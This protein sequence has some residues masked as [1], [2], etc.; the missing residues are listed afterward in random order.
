M[1]QGRARFDTRAGRARHRLFDRLLATVAAP[2]RLR[3][4]AT[5]VSRYQRWGVQRLARRS[6]LLQL[7]GLHR[8][9]ALLPAPAAA[10]RPLPA[11]TPPQ[12]AHRGDVALFTGCI[13]RLA[14]HAAQ[15]ATADLLSRLGYGVHAPAA[16][17]CCGAL[18]AHNGDPDVAR[19][20]AAAN[21]DA[22]AS[23]E[24]EAIVHSA[25]GCTAHLA[26][27]P[28]QFAADAGRQA[29]AQ[30]FK[31]R[32]RDSGRF[33]AEVIARDGW[34]Q[35]L[36]PAPLARTV[37]I[38]EPCS[39]RNVLRESG[40][41]QRLLGLIPQLTTQTLP[42][43]LGCCG[44]GG[45]NLLTQPEFSR[46]LRQKTLDAIAGMEAEILVTSNIGCA[47]HLAAGL[48]EQG[49]EIEVLHPITLLHKQLVQ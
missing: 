2:A 35:N 1:D 38:H 40:T 11:Y 45:G 21:L 19:E 25:S 37:L 18:H 27:Y 30:Q 47:L 6:G 8:V 13:A 32:V 43:S 42:A 49:R 34:P 7:L 48:R 5:W 9:E 15:A 46:R 22:F 28:S 33:L 4:L 17:T 23:L 10:P 36:A 39:Q 26:E 29:L 31:S 41:A 3:R 16:Q 24:V 20:L 44:A 12:G 14:D